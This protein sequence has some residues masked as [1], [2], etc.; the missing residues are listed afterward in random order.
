M[1]IFTGNYFAHQHL[2][3]A[4]V[5]FGS[6]FQDI[7]IM[8]YD[9]HRQTVQDYLV[10]CG[11]GNHNKWVIITNERP[12]FTSPQVQITMPRIGF[13]IVQMTPNFEN[14]IGFNGT[15]MKA[16]L[17]QGGAMKAFNPV[18]YDITIELSIFTKDND[19]N[20]QV[21]EQIIPYFQPFLTLNMVILPELNI[22]KDIPISLLDVKTTDSYTSAADEQ[23]FVQTTMTFTMPYYFYGPTPN[24]AGK[25]IKDVRISVT[26]DVK[27][28]IEVQVSPATANQQDPHTVITTVKP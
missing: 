21:V 2:K 9:E 12:D 16:S 7:K 11:Y 1:S 25:Q 13:E 20:F 14:K 24:I 15:F 5:A 6:I 27:E 28:T 8:K 19:D 4:I 10:P 17:N 23:R 3:N 18:P 22:T 26:G